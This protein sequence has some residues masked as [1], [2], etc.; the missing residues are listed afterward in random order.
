MRR[1]NQIGQYVEIVSALKHVV[2]RF[3]VFPIL[4]FA[5]LVR[6]ARARARI[7]AFHQRARVVRTFPGRIHT[8]SPPRALV[9]VTHVVLDGADR[10]SRTDALRRTLDGVLETLAA[11]SPSIVLN[12]MPERHVI[13][14]LP[15][16]QRTIVEVREHP[17]VDPMFVG[18]RAQDEFLARVEKF[19]WFLYL[20]DD[21][22][23]ADGL[24]LE[25]LHFFNEGAPAHALLLP[26]RYE[27]WNGRKTYIDRGPDVA[28]P[29]AWNRLTT[30]EIGGW[31]FA[32]FENPHS[33]TY[34]LSRAQL[35]RWAASG[36]RWYGRVTFVA[37]RES[38]ATG[39]LA[40][41][42]SIYKPHPENAN[43]LEVRHW[44]TKYS[45]RI[46]EAEGR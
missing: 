19:D 36:R 33:A 46:A 14:A 3:V 42:F 11:A 9:A 5:E 10:A 4:A 44:D 17:D 29:P 8:S 41:A 31:R 28:K 7:T 6:A 25:K 37:P 18:F 15:A 24:L 20:E 38:A 12:T 32:E 30:L 23:F 27:M 16:Y 13:E 45:E 35:D 22:V 43:F 2:T 21:M 39:S 1:R 26:L 40:E 34:C